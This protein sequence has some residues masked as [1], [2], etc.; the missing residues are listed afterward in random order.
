MA[1]KNAVSLVV[2]LGCLLSIAGAAELAKQP[3]PSAGMPGLLESRAA[4]MCADC[5][6]P[7]DATTHKQVLEGLVNNPY[8][9]ELRKALYVQDILHQ[10]ESKAHFDNCDF[11]SSTEYLTSLLEEAS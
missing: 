1:R 2:V 4:A 5:D 7:F 3:P 10:F 8:I 11:E 9:A 6:E